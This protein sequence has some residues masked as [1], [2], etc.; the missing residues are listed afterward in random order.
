MGYLVYLFLFL[1]FIYNALDQFAFYIYRMPLGKISAFLIFV[2]SLLPFLLIK[3]VIIETPDEVR[4]KEWQ[5]YAFLVLIS[6]IFGTI[7]LF[8]E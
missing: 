1:F 4:N 3:Q 8:L 5:L 7:S 6:M 2:I